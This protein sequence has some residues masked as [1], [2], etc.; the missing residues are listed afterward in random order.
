MGGSNMD[1]DAELA[2]AL[3]TSLSVALPPLLEKTTEAVQRSDRVR[4]LLQLS[5]RNVGSARIGQAIASRLDDAKAL[6]ELTNLLGGEHEH[7]TQAALSLGVEDALTALDLC[8]AAAFLLTAEP[9]PGPADRLSDVDELR[10][11]QALPPPLR[12]WVNDVAASPAFADLRA[13]RHALVHRDYS[14]LQG[15]LLRNDDGAPREGPYPATVTVYSRENGKSR[16]HELR[17]A[18]GLPMLVRLAREWVVDFHRAFG[19]LAG[20]VPEDV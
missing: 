18:T 17:L 20:L 5:M 2:R 11:D 12:Q 9:L 14:T 19:K 8:A 6:A 13:L 4:L 10:K 3:D 1:L 16:Q 7:W 15:I